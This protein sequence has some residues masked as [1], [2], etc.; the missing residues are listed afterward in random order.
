MGYEA[1]D[2]HPGAVVVGGVEAEPE[3]VVVLHVENA[4]HDLEED[5]ADQHQQGEPL[6]H[7][8][9][10]SSRW[11]GEQSRDHRP[12]LREHNRD[13]DQSQ[14][15]METLVQAVEPG[16]VR[17]PVEQR[18]VQPPDIFGPRLGAVCD[19]R[20]QTRERDERQRDKEDQTEDRREPGPPQWAAPRS[21]IQS[22][23]SVFFDPA[24]ETL[25]K[26]VAG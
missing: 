4:G 19:V 18:E 8:G 10:R 12:Q 14:G 5:A 11:P 1:G 21:R 2:E 6:K 3:D 20:Q 26:S 17:R 16:G 24:P 13:Q 9:H 23:R 22:G 15:D 25:R 7:L